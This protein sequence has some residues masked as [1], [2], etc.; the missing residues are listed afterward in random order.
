MSI[1]AAFS[2]GR[3]ACGVLG[4][5][6]LNEFGGYTEDEI[7]A[8]YAATDRLITAFQEIDA[9]LGGSYSDPQPHEEGA[10]P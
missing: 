2:V 8:Q 4:A 10:T 3:Q 9:G 1:S 7:A 6:P 5:A